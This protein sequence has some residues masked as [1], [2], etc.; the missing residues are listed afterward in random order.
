[1]QDVTV[2]RKIG[3]KNV[4][5]TKKTEQAELLITVRVVNNMGNHSEY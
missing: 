4:L 5:L 2:T 3:N 1:M